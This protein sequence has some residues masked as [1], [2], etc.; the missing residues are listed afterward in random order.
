MK[1]VED[2]RLGGSLGVRL[3]QALD[4]LTPNEYLLSKDCPSQFQMS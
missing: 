2:P 1:L 3:Y 4:G